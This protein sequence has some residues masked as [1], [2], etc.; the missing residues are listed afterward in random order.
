MELDDEDGRSIIAAAA[1]ARVQKAEKI[2]QE[3]AL[4]EVILLI[5]A[6]IETF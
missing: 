1:V 3:S 5:N 4:W 6:Y 2:M